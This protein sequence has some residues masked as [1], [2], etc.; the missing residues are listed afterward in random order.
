[1]SE[2]GGST[3]PELKAM[4]SRWATGERN[5]QP[6]TVKVQKGKQRAKMKVCNSRWTVQGD[7]W[8]VSSCPA[9][10]KV[11]RRRW[12]VGVDLRWSKLPMDV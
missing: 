1:M 12:E 2:G 5:I 8:G 7:D 11:G 4:A 10:S 9:K 3:N 6:P